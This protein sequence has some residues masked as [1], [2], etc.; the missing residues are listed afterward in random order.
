MSGQVAFT[1]QQVLGHRVRVQGLH[2]VGPASAVELL[3]IGLPD[4]PVGSA[5]LGLAHR[6]RPVVTTSEPG[7]V[8]ALTV[9]GAPHL[10]RRTDLPALRAALVPTDD[11]EFRALLG[12]HGATIVESGVDG[13]ELVAVTAIALRG[14][15]CRRRRRHQGRAVRDGERGPA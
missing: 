1:R 12:G 14:T 15:R 4:T 9:R 6:V 10:H 5:E 8:L 11:A 2:G 3:A 7:L 13:P